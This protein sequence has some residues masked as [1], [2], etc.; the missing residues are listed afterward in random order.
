MC[1][2]HV[3]IKAMYAAVVVQIVKYSRPKG[4]YVAIRRIVM[5]GLLGVVEQNGT[6]EDLPG[7]WGFSSGKSRTEIVYG[8]L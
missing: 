6:V 8:N 1:A 2:E 4:D 7:Y 3:L 5:S